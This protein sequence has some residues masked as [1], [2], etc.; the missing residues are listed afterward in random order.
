MALLATP[1]GIW[2]SVEGGLGVN[3]EASFDGDGGLDPI[4]LIFMLIGLVLL[5]VVAAS[6]GSSAAGPLVA[7]VVWGVAPVLVHSLAPDL[8]T[9]IGEEFDEVVADWF[10]EYALVIFPLVTALMLGALVAGRRGRTA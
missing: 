7:A 3:E 4:Y 10:D 1:V 6:G 9:R 8:F 5:A 2:W